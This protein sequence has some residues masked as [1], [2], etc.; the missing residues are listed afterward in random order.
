MSEYVA[1]LRDIKFILDHV[2]PIKELAK[3][4]PYS[5]IDSASVEGVLEEFGRLMSEVWAPTNAVGDHEGLAGLGL[6]LIRQ[7]LKP[8]HHGCGDLHAGA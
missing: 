4:A 6:I 1:P 8:A 7:R 2:T 3:L 5:E